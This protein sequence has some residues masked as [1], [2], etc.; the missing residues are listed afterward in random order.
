MLEKMLNSLCCPLCGEELLLKPFVE[1]TIELERDEPG[2]RLEKELLDKTSGKRIQEGVLLC[3]A[4]KVYYPIY[5]YVPVMLVFETNF[6]KKFAKENAQKLQLF[7]GY[8]TPNGTAR[9]GEKSVQET[10]TDQW[11]T[12]EDSE[13]SFTYTQEELKLLNQKVWLKWLSN[14]N[15]GQYIKKVLDVGCGIGRES[16]ALQEVTNSE[17]FAID[18]NFT[19]FKGAELFKKN[20]NI[21][22][23]IASLFNLPFKKETFDLVYSEGVIHHTFSTHEALK[24]I[25]SYVENGKYLFIWVYAIEDRMVRRGLV[26]IILRLMYVV[27]TIL[28]PLISRSPKVLR[29]IIF[30]ILTLIF[31]PMDK[32]VNMNSEKWELKNTNHGLRDWLSPRYAFRQGY[33]EVLEWFEELE[34]KIIDI[35][36]PATYRKLFNKRLWGIGL[37]G[38]KV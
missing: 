12:V 35:Q 9:P 33:N 19:L 3:S 21:N 38:K 15:V 29:D 36:S 16:V 17:I 2:E 26:G 34:F 37:T 20:Q 13:L 8:K 32:V 7:S 6:H 5:S 31:Y 30:W 27:E 28:R 18:L 24:S 23:A 1:E 10:F 25:A 11:D 14:D 4:C 22:F